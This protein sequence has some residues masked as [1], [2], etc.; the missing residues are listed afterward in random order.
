MNCNFSKVIFTGVAAV[1]FASSGAAQETA[2]HKWNF[3]IAGGFTAPAGATADHFEGS[4]NIST[5]GGYNFSPLLGIVGEF[6]YNA[7]GFSTTTLN[8]LNVPDGNAHIWSLTANPIVRLPLGHRIGVYFTGGGGL[9]QRKLEFTSP[10]TEAVFNPIFGAIGIPTNQILG[11]V[12]STTG[13]LDAGGGLTYAL[14]ESGAKLYVESRYNHA[15][16]DG[17]GTSYVPVSIGIR[18]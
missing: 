14:R 2:F 18:W 10:A 16:T 9:Y 5:G 7:L 13:G 3:N 15:F 6:Q 4:G 17:P 12:T 1:L 11:S 8:A